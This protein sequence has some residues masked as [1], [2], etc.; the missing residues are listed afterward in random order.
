MAQLNRSPVRGENISMSVKDSTKAKNIL[1]A[2]PA[3]DFMK[4]GKL[5]MT[6]KTRHF[7]R[8]VDL[9]NDETHAY[10]ST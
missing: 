5:R 2:K 4:L 9:T 7:V 1:Y 6:E 10:Q 8:D 3:E